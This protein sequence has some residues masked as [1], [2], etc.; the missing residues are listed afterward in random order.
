MAMHCIVKGKVQ[1]VW[2]RQSTLE[3]AQ[4]L[5]LTGWVRNNDNGEVEL[6]ACGEESALSNLKRWL[7]QGPEHANVQEV[8][9][10]EVPQQTFDKFT[11]K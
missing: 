10:E 6:L 9:I 5:G 2:F 3:Q 11:I 8:I 1:G 7:W 4:A